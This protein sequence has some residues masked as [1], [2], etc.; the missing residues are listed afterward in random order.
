MRFINCFSQ[1]SRFI[2]YFTQSLRFINCFTQSLIFINYFTQSLRFLKA[3]EVSEEEKA[4]FIE[5]NSANAVV[6]DAVQEKE[7]YQEN[8]VTKMLTPLMAPLSGNQIYKPYFFALF[9]LFDPFF[10]PCS[11]IPQKR[12]KCMFSNV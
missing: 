9:F 3:N 1:S 8:I 5:N 12:F 6:L 10:T 7:V 2:N 4:D 11:Q